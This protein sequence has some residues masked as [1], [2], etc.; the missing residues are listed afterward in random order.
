MSTKRKAEILLFVDVSNIRFAI[1][2]ISILDQTNA[3]VRDDFAASQI[4][5][6]FKGFQSPLRKLLD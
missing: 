2:A 1:N 4:D 6:D 3:S 5:L